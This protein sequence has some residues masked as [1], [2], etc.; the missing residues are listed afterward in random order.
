VKVV[1]R[2]ESSADGAVEELGSADGGSVV[3][4]EALGPD[5]LEV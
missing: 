2:F 1:G 3:I 4:G 5:V